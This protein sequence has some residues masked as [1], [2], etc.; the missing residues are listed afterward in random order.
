MISG[1]W[2]ASWPVLVSMH[3]RSFPTDAEWDRHL[4]MARGIR[5]V[6][7][8]S[9]TI[10]VLALS[11]GGGPT[12]AQRA[13]LFARAGRHVVRAALVTKSPTAGGIG[14]VV[15][16][17]YPGVK[18]FA[19]HEFQRALAHLDIPHGDVPSL[20]NH[21]RAADAELGLECVA[22]I[23]VRLAAGS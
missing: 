17:T 2:R 3:G 9:A 14:T 15:G 1:V 5:D 11:D 19:P 4:D 23:L 10:R 20:L 13:K 12:S 18:V 21:I 7:G 8:E 22:D 16:L 6:I